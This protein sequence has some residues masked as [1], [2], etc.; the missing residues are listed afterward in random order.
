MKNPVYDPPDDGCVLSLT[1]L[2][3][4]GSR[5]FDRSQYGNH[6]VI[7]GAVW[8]KLPGGLWCLSFDGI[9]DKV[10]F[11]GDGILNI[12]QTLTAM[13]WIKSPS[14][15]SDRVIIGKD[16]SGAGEE[17]WFVRISS[18]KTQFRACKA[19][20]VWTTLDGNVVVDDDAFHQVAVR[21]LFSGDGTSLMNILIDGKLDTTVSSAVG[22]I[23]STANPLNLGQ[24]EYSGYENPFTGLIALPR[25]Y[26]RYLSALEIQNI[27]NCEKT[28]FGVW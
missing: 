14:L 23:Q 28:M 20:G 3:G 8:T 16:R 15:A 5:I 2:T 13:A 1:G 21:Y 25:I 22:P 27:F 24:K 7:T 19:D 18:H 4:G 11:A 10:S 17:A 12:T 26:N 9:D 6:G